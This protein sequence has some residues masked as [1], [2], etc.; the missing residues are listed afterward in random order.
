MKIN[1]VV[2][3]RE[4]AEALGLTLARCLNALVSIDGEDEADLVLCDRLPD[5]DTVTAAEEVFSGHTNYLAVSKFEPVTCVIDRIRSM[6]LRDGE[7]VFDVPVIAV[8]GL[9]SVSV[10]TVAIVMARLYS[11]I[12]DKRIMYI[13]FDALGGPSDAFVYELLAKG[14]VDLTLLAKD[15]FN[16]IGVENEPAARLNPL[17][18]L[19]TGEVKSFLRLA[20][21]SD[22]YDLIVMNVP[23]ASPHWELCM[24]VSEVTVAVGDCAGVDAISKIY[25]AETKSAGHLQVFE[26]C[27]RDEPDIYGELGARVRDLILEISGSQ[28][29]KK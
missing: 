28:L 13:S 4:Y 18:K 15:A 2:S 12:M 5:K 22:Q 23:L 1:I 14:N 11:R 25:D 7:E 8:T 20:G 19:S 16:V 26:Y 9:E 10:S 27:D 24:K 17:R 3:D 6:V 21:T 29:Y